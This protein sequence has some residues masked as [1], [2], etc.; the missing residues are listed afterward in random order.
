MITALAD[1]ILALA[2]GLE[3]LAGSPRRITSALA[4]L[5]VRPS[6]LFIA[7]SLTLRLSIA[8]RWARRRR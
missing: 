6:L 2:R 7:A 8:S 3:R 5:S 1:R 4:K